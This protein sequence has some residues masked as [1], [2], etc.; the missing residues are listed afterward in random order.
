MLLAAKFGFID[1]DIPE[2]KA[3]RSQ[4]QPQLLT[5]QQ[6]DTVLD[7]LL[8]ELKT[9]Q[10]FTFA[11]A[12]VTES[13]L[14]D[15]KSTFLDL[16]KK[17]IRGKLLTSNYLN[18]NNPKVFREL[19]KITNLD[20][21][22]TDEY[23]FHTKTY[24]F[25]HGDYL[26]VII[27]SS[28]LT[29]NA[30]KRNIE[31]NLR[32]TSTQQGDI[33]NQVSHKL[34]DMW[35]KAE[36]LTDKWIDMYQSNY[37]K[38]SPMQVMQTK[39]P[40]KV[41]I[42]PNKMQTPALDE[43]A[44]L[45]GKGEHK[46]L[47]VAA[48]GT[49]KTYLAAF[50]VRQYAPKR[51]LF[52]VHREQ[53]LRK[54]KESF[55][56]V[57]GGNDS[58]YGILSGNEKNPDAKYLFATINMAASQGFLEKN[59]EDAFDYIIIDEAHRIGRDK[60]GAKPTLYEKFLNHFKSD[61]LLGMTATPQRTD[62]VNAYEFFDYNVAYEISL[63]DAL[64]EDLL[65]PFHYIGVTDYE[66]QGELIADSTS[67][68]NLVSKERV[69]YLIEKTDYYGYSG[70]KLH[71]LI[72]VSRIEEG[73][74]LVDELNKR[75]IKARFLSGSDG[76]NIRE[77]TVKLLEAG[78][79]DYIVTVDVFNEGIDIP[80]I[81]QVVLMRPTESS[82]IFL[83]QLGRGLRKNKSKEYV[84]VIDFIGNYQNNY[85]IPIA[86]DSSHSSNK[87]KLR[88]NTIAPSISGVS[89]IHFEE[90]AAKKI[91]ESI[92]ETKFNSV[93][94][95]KENYFS[96]KQKIGQNIPMLM[97][98]IKFGTIS[99]DDIVDKY[100][101]VK[102]L[103]FN[104]ED[105][106]TRENIPNFDD[107]LTGYLT[108]INKEIAVSKRIVELILI[109]ELIRNGEI[110]DERIYQICKDNNYYIDDETL[111][112]VARILNF[113][114]FL[115]S[116]K[117]DYGSYGLALYKN[118][119]WKLSDKFK[120]ALNNI[121]FKEYVNDAV[122]AGFSELTANYNVKDKFEIGQKYL[123]K[124]VIKM[125]NWNKEQTGQNVGGYIKRSDN[126]FLPMFVNLEKVKAT[127]LVAYEDEFINRETMIWYSKNKRSLQSP[128]EKVI[129]ES[130]SFGFIQVFVK[131][132]DEV[133]KEGISFYYLGS[134]KVI[135][136]E[137]EAIK[138]SQGNTT[139]LI[140]FE[141]QLQ[142]PVDY[143]LFL[144]LTE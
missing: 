71:G 141:I 124:D 100:K 24:L 103:Q 99:V 56:E 76:P 85:M 13:G 106:Y 89:T 39:T 130:D 38:P 129:S 105:I 93:K 44:T 110:S 133:T 21:R 63:F 62:G 134:A 7:Y 84:T 108:F 131:R 96:V 55:K 109:Q 90:V 77:A 45:R 128:T 120:Q 36:V 101:T 43:L 104:M 112:S 61:F 16:A 102:N 70:E 18:F 17:G 67:L 135:S 75:E 142:H 12:F 25:N 34:D 126:K 74:Q 113:S 125:L 58:D 23:G 114:Y 127:N 122:T 29:Q 57:L 35:N 107:E 136:S 86:L 32:V 117:K 8:Q 91:L 46:A 6:N 48:T 42:K 26:S 72:F 73:Q 10:S 83:Q 123:R 98:L 79:I 3:V 139:N 37:V 88:K 81:N 121:V 119:N 94:R 132:S 11:V 115:N 50:D 1:K 143:D 95:F 2:N 140:K 80:I 68:K 92:R 20:V 52:V 78:K 64:E 33:L 31:W 51:L 47:V 65:A 116:T 144:A 118:N 53:I 82:I 41:A 111:E 28:N 97:D 19:L 9:S 66:Y 137:E 138:D 60:D 22:V 5:N 87:E 40:Y 15:L 59:S 14:I 54:A 49:G 27:G 30:L 4:L 69:N